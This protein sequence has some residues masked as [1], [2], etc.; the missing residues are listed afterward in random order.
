MNSLLEIFE[1][2]LAERIF[3]AQTALT[4]R[5]S[6]LEAEI[7]TLR[8]AAPETAATL[9]RDGRTLSERVTWLENHITD[10]DTLAESIQNVLSDTDWDNM[11]GDEVN[12]PVLEAQCRALGRPHLLEFLGYRN[13]VAS[14]LAQLDVLIYLLNPCHYGTAENTLLEAMAMGVVPVVLDNPA[15]RHLVRHGETGLVVAGPGAFAEALR[16]LAE[17]PDQR[18][19]L[20][21]A[22]STDVRTRFAVSHT[23]EALH[24][25]YRAVLGEVKRTWDFRS[26]FGDTPA[27]W[28]RSCQGREAWRFRDDGSVDLDGDPPHALFEGRKGSVFV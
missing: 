4:D 26:I 12:R 14:E 25:H 15:E 19:S 28:F 21:D 13:D 18:R 27:Q 10:C 3:Y 6:V 7:Q 23:V 16:R 5:I 24:R 9:D 22:A 17:R 2:W 11:I 8:I 20:G 1:T